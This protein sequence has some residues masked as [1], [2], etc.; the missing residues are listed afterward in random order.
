MNARTAVPAVFLSIFLAAAPVAASAYSGPEYW[1]STPAFSVTPLKG[2]PITVE[3]EDLTFDFSK[4]K[5]FRYSPSAD[6]SA[7]Y[8]MKNPTGEAVRV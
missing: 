1:E 7:A 3:R 8:R 2:S 4:N 5:S 6:V